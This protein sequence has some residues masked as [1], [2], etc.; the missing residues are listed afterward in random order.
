MSFAKIHYNYNRWVGRRKKERP[1]LK[2]ISLKQI[3]NLINQLADFGLIRIEKVEKTNCYFLP[4]H[5]KLPD[6][7][8]NENTNVNENENC[9]MILGVASGKCGFTTLRAF[10]T[11][12]PMVCRLFIYLKADVIL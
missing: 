4:L 6:E 11:L 9:P 10:S 5:N 2:T 8:S 3:K 12:I 1:E 7:N